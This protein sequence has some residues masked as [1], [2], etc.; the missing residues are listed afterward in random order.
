MYRLA[1]AG[2]IC[3][4]AACGMHLH[5]QAAELAQVPSLDRDGEGREARVADVVI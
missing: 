4:H 3:A 5:V 1:L 2:C